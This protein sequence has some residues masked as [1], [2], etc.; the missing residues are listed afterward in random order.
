V[1][2]CVGVGVKYRYNEHLG[3][4]Y[5]YDVPE[6]SQWKTEMK[7]EGG[8]YQPNLPVTIRVGFEFRGSL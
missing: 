4:R 1:E 2:L 3:R 5:P 7:R 8:S 6:L